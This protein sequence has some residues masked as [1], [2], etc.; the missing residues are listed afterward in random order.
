ML[1]RAF[2]ARDAEAVAAMVAA[3]NAEEGYNRATAADA[4]ALRDAFLGPRAHGALLVAGDPPQGYATLHPSYETEFA[5]RGAYMGDLYVAP[6]VRRQGVG[7]ALVAA[8]ARH[9]R[10]AWG[11]SFLW[12]TA[13]PKNAAGQAFYASLGAEGEDIRAFALTR[14]VFA[15]L[16]ASA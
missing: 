12:W 4:A 16:A 9:T 13:L 1:I 8:A 2:D 7:R 15:R 11:G 14:D 3:L 6:A 10:E 5:A